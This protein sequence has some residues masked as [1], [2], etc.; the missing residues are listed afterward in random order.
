MGEFSAVILAAGE[1][2]RMKSNTPKV[3]HKICGYPMLHYV[4][5]CARGAGADEI[6]VVVG[7]GAEEV[8]KAFENENVKFVLQPE[9]KGT[10]HALMQAEEEV[11][12]SKYIMVL[13]GDMPLIKPETLKNLFN[14]HIENQ[15]AAT[16]LTCE[17]D[18]PYGYGRIIKK[19][20][21]VV[22]IREEKDAKKEEKLIKEINSGI[23]CFETQKVFSALKNVKNENRQGEY[24]LTDVVEIFNNEGEKVLAFKI[25]NPDE[26]HGIND[27]VQLAKA[28]AIM[29]KEIV[30]NLMKDGV[31]FINPESC[32]VDAGV[33]IGRD[34]V[35]YPGAVI[36]GKTQIGESCL[37]LGNSVI[38]D[39][40]IGNN[41]EILSSFVVESEIGDGVKIGPFA[42]LR[43]GTRLSSHV[44]IGDFVEV[45]NST[46][47]EG[48]KIPHLSYVGD[49]EI[50]AGVN[51]GAGVIFVNYDGYKKHKTVVQDNAFIGCNSNL[52]A[53][54]KIEEGAYVAAGSTLTK[55]V[56][57]KALA[58]ARAKQENKPGWVE[59]R[60]KI[61]EG[62]K[63]NGGE[64]A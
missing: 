23:Y 44:K 12:G 21:R 39:S 59:K 56:P 16:V 30:E 42:N 13:Y 32:V 8:K 20:G 14:F 17:F 45:K 33:K 29:Q 57:G 37:I 11:K 22:A 10:G 19:E 36:E 58:I 49:A 18:N 52:I 50:G 41:V 26:V 5:N 60:K 38:R 54:L 1:G 6:V 2:T 3:L 27:R 15:P 47:G 53:P 4:I 9:Q 31:T 62:G 46:V 24:Y 51:I 34:T 64:Q 55:D 43:P 28:R 63:T 7:R 40:K 35:I 25:E 48:T 61:F